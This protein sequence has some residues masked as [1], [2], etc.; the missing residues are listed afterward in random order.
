[1]IYHTLQSFYFR[2]YLFISHPK[3]W[4][5]NYT[6]NSLF[7]LF[8]SESCTLIFQKKNIL[9]IFRKLKILFYF[10]EMFEVSW[11]SKSFPF[12]FFSN[13]FIKFSV[14]YSI[15]ATAFDG[16]RVRICYHGYSL[17]CFFFLVCARCRAGD[18]NY[19]DLT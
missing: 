5:V 8:A 2:S 15:I 18:S 9:R 17:K 7:S 1:M 16:H 10:Q 13:V 12:A 4:V 19:W 6:R 3:R 14:C 11:R